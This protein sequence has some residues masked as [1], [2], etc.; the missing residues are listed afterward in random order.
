MPL[1]EI[2]ESNVLPNGCAKA[3][4]SK[5]GA[6]KL[7]EESHDSIMA[8]IFRRET[9]EDVHC[10]QETEGTTDIGSSDSSCS[11]SSCSTS[12]DSE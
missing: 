2:S 12:N 6:R 11:S 1:H 8:E 4:A 9:L 5:K 3:S 7:S 10:E